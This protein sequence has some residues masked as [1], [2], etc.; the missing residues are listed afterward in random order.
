MGAAMSMMSA[1]QSVGGIALQGDA[2]AGDAS[3]QRATQTV[4][5]AVTRA[6]KQIAEDLKSKPSPTTVTRR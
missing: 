4:Q 1:A 3:T 6:G 5:D 2:D